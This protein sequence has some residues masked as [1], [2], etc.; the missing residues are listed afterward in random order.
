LQRPKRQRKSVLRPKGAS[1][2]L[3]TA[4]TRRVLPL[5][6]QVSKPAVPQV[7][8]PAGGRQTW[9]SAARQVWKPALQKMRCAQRQKYFKINLAFRLISSHDACLL[10]IFSGSLFTI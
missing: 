3:A 1:H 9:K 7:S 2:F 6:A 5:V 4:Q 10:V 8:K